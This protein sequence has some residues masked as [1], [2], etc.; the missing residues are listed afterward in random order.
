MKSELKVEIKMNE[1]CG[2]ITSQPELNGNSN[3]TKSLDT[4]RNPNFATIH[5][6]PNFQFDPDRV[7]LIIPVQTSSVDGYYV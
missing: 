1:S 4:K 5:E 3:N 6:S 2:R 7:L